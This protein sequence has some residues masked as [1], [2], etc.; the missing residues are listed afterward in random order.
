MLLQPLTRAV[1]QVL[2]RMEHRGGCG[3]EVNTGDGI[4]LSTFI[5]Q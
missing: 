4:V 3:C 2:E 1:G 5:L